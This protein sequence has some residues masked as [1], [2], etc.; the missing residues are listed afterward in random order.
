MNTL[1][2]LKAIHGLPGVWA[3]VYPSDTAPMRWT[4]P[5]AIVVNT[6]P[7]TKPGSHWIAM[8]LNNLGHCIYFD[9]YG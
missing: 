3:G 1:Q 6:D 8:Y 4:K 9:S 5:A 7:H 2:I